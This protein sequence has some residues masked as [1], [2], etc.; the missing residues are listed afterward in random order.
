MAILFYLNKAKMFAKQLASGVKASVV[1]TKLTYTSNI[2]K[3]IQKVFFPQK[4]LSFRVPPSKIILSPRI[5]NTKI[6]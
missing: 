4:S 2:K 5:A 3:F 6:C 1:R